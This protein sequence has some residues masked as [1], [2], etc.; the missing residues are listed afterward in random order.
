MN[1]YEI[2]GVEP[3]D[4][5]DTIKR[6]YRKASSAAHPDREGGSTEKQQQVNEAYAILSDPAKR[7]EFNATGKV[8]GDDIR[9]QAMEMA[10][11]VFL[12][13][14]DNEWFS[15][16]IKESVEH[17]KAECVKARD[18]ANTCVR[19]IKRLGKLESR[20]KVK[21]GDNILGM[22]LR[23]AIDNLNRAFDAAEKFQA[24]AD[25]AIEIL[26]N[27]ELQPD[28]AG[29]TGFRLGSSFFSDS[30]FNKDI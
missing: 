27:H 29:T 12:S 14:V 30:L 11:A 18:E 17:L 16:P 8:S 5:D 13:K 25:A 19:R 24:R 21:Q 4:D 2:L 22:S 6:A 9:A 28:H 20:L 7:S 3:Q 1:P 15:D 23:K 26:Q 10:V